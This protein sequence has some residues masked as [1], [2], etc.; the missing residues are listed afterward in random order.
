LN[1]KGARTKATFSGSMSSKGAG[2]HKLALKQNAVKECEQCHNADSKFFRNVSVA[3]VRADGTEM[4]FDA[5]QEV[6]GSLFSTLPAGQFYVLGGTRLRLL[7]YVGILMVVGG[8]TFPIAH[9]AL[10]ALTAPIRR[11]R[12]E[13]HS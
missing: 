8:A 6:L 9:L 7:D 4:L 12:K 13:K 2:A 10:R 11:N 5:R 1:E 3:I